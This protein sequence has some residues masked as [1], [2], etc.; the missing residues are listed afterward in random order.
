LHDRRRLTMTRKISFQLLS[1]LLLSSCSVTNPKSLPESR[2][3]DI[4]PGQNG[5]F[6]DLNRGHI[7][8]Y[9]VYFGSVPDSQS[10]MC[11]WIGAKGELISMW[12][13]LPIDDDKLL[14]IFKEIPDR[15]S[16]NV[17]LWVSDRQSLTPMEIELAVR[18][19]CSA[20]RKASPDSTLSIWI[21]PIATRRQ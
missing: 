6:V 19:I 9:V 21:E 3:Q 1:L 17:E 10:S 20:A 13:A 4:E 8:K 15:T 18:R 2:W 14:S 5:G 7:Q 16:A 12:H 11:I